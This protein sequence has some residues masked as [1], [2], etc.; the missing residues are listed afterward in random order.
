MDKYGRKY[1]TKTDGIGGEIKAEPGDFV[2]EEIGTTVNYKLIERISDLFPKK[3][4]EQLHCT[5]VKTN[6]TTNRAVARISG[7]LRVSRKRIGYAGMKDKRAITSQ[8]I[9]IY[10][11]NKAIIK[12][13]RM[14]DIELKN[15]HYSDKRIEL[16]DL[17][18]NVFTIRILNHNGD[19]KIVEEFTKS[20]FFPNYFG[21]Q[22]FGTRRMINHRIGISILKGDLKTAVK[23]ML[24]ETGDE[25]EEATKAREKLSKN[26]GDFKTALKEFPKY[27]GIEKAMMN[28]LVKN[29]TDY[30]GALRTIPKR[31]RIMFTHSVQSYIFN[32]TLSSY[33]ETPPKFLPL[34]G[35]QT[36]SLPEAAKKIVKELGIEKK[37]FRCRV[38]PEMSSRGSMR[39]SMF[40]IKDMKILELNE[41]LIKLRFMLEKGI[42]ATTVLNELMK[43]EISKDRL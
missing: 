30:V 18:G 20:R 23:I 28:Y 4:K 38:M 10:R 43:K 21:E 34:V 24:T 5:L 3:R 13:L 7:K 11:G 36:E 42:Y 37:D 1:W 22:R 40:E 2:V 35:F 9:S 14:K 29:P 17:S 41:N 33:E 39:K 31:L 6:Y 12:K 16:G 15:F 27:L 25:S 32:L 26:W 19:K 8:R